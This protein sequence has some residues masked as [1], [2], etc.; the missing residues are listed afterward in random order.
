MGDGG[1]KGKIALPLRRVY[2]APCLRSRLAAPTSL[3]CA[4]QI[5]RLLVPAQASAS[6]NSGPWTARDDQ[7]GHLARVGKVPTIT[8]ASPLCPKTTRWHASTSLTRT[9]RGAE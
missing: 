2:A 9:T 8:P 7:A 5:T 6:L 3:L 4:A 1:E